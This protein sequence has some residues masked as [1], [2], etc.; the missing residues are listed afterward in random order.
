[1]TMSLSATGSRKAPDRV[2]PSRRAS[3]PSRLSVAVIAN[4]RPTVAHDEPSR[5]MTAWSPGRTL[6]ETDT[7]S[8]LVTT[9]DVAPQGGKSLVSITTS[10][11]GASGIGGFFERTFAP[12]AVERLYREA[13]DRLNAYATG[14]R[15]A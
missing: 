3:Q 13:L 1:M 15:T 4:H 2:A 12:R 9:Y 7:G 14:H 10:W 5:R 6:V 11:D 8:S